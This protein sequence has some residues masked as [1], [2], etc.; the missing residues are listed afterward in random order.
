M[1]PPAAGRVVA[2]VLAA[3]GSTRMGSRPKLLLP[4][5]GEALVRWP[6]LAA[7]A[8][9][10]DEVGVVVG[11]EADRVTRVL[12]DL[13]VHRIDNP[14][15]A[16]GLSGSLSRGLEWAAA[17][18]AAALVLLGDEPDIRPEAI[19]RVL[20]D[21]RA[22]PEGGCRARYSDRIGHPVVVDAGRTRAVSGD[23]GLRGRGVLCGADLREVRI[24]APAPSDIDTPADYREALARLPH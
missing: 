7:L 17:R 4:Y 9:G 6:V 10:L 5:R 19:A 23:R 12:A 15:F 11:D 8:A 21:W 14:A 20:E 16:E 18:E 1:T 24:D 2:V 3:G 13:P 22:R